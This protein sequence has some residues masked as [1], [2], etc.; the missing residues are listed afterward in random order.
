MNFLLTK[1]ELHMNYKHLSEIERYHIKRLL[2]MGKTQKEIAE[3]LGRSPSTISREIR[4]NSG[5]KGY[6]NKQAHQFS[7]NRHKNK[8]K[9]TKLDAQV[10]EWIKQLLKQ[11][12][13]PE[14]ISGY[15][16]K[17]CNIKLHHETIYR[18]IFADKQA[19]GLL[20][21]S[22]RIANKK[23]R[24]RFG[25]TDR[26]GKIS[27]RVSIHDR[28]TCIENKIRIGDLEGDTII[29]KNR[30]GAL[31]TLVDRKTLYTFIA[32]LE[33]KNAT[34]LSEKVIS[35]LKNVGKIH[36]ITFDNGL[37]FAKHKMIAEALNIDIYF[38][39]PYSSWQRG[40]NENTNGL[41]R[42]YFPKD[43]DFTKVI[44]EQIQRVQEELNN[45]PR[46]TRGYKTPNE[47]FFGKIKDLLIT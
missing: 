29:G 31:L 15:L 2:K 17:H 1:K 5:K 19:G 46:K 30:K 22:L 28:P 13:S 25:K 42:Q 20:Y 32:K 12:L 16:E 39:D 33:G 23:Y 21:K 3:F 40:I 34:Q 4:R 8:P 43:T 7:Q 37:E 47:L 38:A 11:K 36:S 24:R 45:R 26:R 18:F 27:E 9:F 14:Q 35:V 41:I 44:E 6:R 10:V